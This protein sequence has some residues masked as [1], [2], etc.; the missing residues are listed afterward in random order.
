MFT[1]TIVYPE[2]LA[3]IKLASF[4]APLPATILFLAAGSGAGNETIINLILAKIVFGGCT[5]R[6][7]H[8]KCRFM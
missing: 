4:P 1:H 6:T 2:I 3:I 7:K 8:S 5:A